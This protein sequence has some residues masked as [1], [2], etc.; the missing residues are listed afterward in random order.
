MNPRRF[1]SI[2]R[3][4][5]RCPAAPF[6]EHAI[7]AEVEAICTE[8]SLPC[9][10]DRSGNLL[11]EMKR[12][13]PS[14]PLALVAH[15]DHPGFDILK[16]VGR[17]RFRARFLG[18]VP[19]EYFRKGTW[20]RLMPGAIPAR[21]GSQLGKPAGREFEI[22]AS[23]ETVDTPG[24][25]VWEL[26][27]HALRDGRIHGRACDDLVGVAAILTV[28]AEL[29]GSTEAVWVIGAITRAEEIGFGGALA[30]AADRELPASSLVI[31]LETSRELPPVKLGA[32]V[33]VRVGDRGTV[34]HSEPTRFLNEVAIELGRGRSVFPFQRAL[35]SG[36][37]C[38]GTVFSQTGYTTAALC[39][40]LGNYHN[41]GPGRKVAPEYVSRADA[42]GMV[43]LLLAAA[44][45]MP[46]YRS[47]VGRL[48]QRLKKIHR[49]TRGRLRR[50]A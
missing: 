34:F 32:G 47:I 29:R 24:F 13:R 49:Q 48:E 1:D 30:L 9:R 11:V 21:L 39:V 17:R 3:R 5:M 26:A 18:G 40:A 7:R 10:R 41:C 46:E 28:L 25:A 37:T 43:R 45:R 35:M 38:E 44:R 31:S 22:I 14:R 42:L 36:G 4:L 8:H 33:I 23:R 50:P 19:P 2:L 27:D 16:T 15:L 6:H 20:L 12:G